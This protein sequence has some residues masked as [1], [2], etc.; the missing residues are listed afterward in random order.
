[1]AGIRCP[2]CGGSG[3]VPA[4][5]FL[6]E[7]GAHV[8]DLGNAAACPDCMGAGELA[9]GASPIF[10]WK[11]EENFWHAK[12]YG[13]LEIGDRQRDRNKAIEYVRIALRL[14][15]LPAH[16]ETREGTGQPA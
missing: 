16:G 2:R 7:V 10:V 14:E 5:L 4:K 6:Q 9:N 3:Q 15:R 12:H 11:D 13:S 1:M 8:D